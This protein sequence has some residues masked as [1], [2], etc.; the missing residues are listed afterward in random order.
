MKT[1]VMD[2]VAGIEELGDSEVNV[3]R[4]RNPSAVPT[5]ELVGMVE[6]EFLPTIRAVVVHPVRAALPVFMSEDVVT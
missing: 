3:A 1:Y 5:L 6:D 2:H 4:S